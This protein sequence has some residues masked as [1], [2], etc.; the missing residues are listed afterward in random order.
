MT[1][2]LIIFSI[3][4]I[5]FAIVFLIGESIILKKRKNTMVVY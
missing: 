2:T 4:F 5:S 3:Y 1:I